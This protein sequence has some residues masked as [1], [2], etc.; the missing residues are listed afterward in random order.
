MKQKAILSFFL[1]V[2]ERFSLFL[3][4]FF[5]FRI[6]YFFGSEDKTHGGKYFCFL[7]DKIRGKQTCFLFYFFFPG[8]PW[9]H[10]I[11]L[12][13]D[14]DSSFSGIGN[15]I[16]SFVSNYYY[17]DSVAVVNVYRVFSYINARNR[18]FRYF[19]VK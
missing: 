4:F 5:Q 8:V 16:L 17:C 13:I 19:C 12:K 7:R 18:L 9:P 10:R 15:M 6:S 3:L 1:F 2:L 14:L 11:I